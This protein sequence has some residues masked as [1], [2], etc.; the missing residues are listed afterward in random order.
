MLLSIKYTLPPGAFQNAKSASCKQHTTHRPVNKFK[1]PQNSSN[2]GVHKIHVVGIWDNGHWLGLTFCFQHG[3]SNSLLQLILHVLA[4]CEFQLRY[5]HLLFIFKT[6][7]NTLFF[8]KIHNTPCMF[9]ACILY[10]L[11]QQDLSPFYTGCRVLLFAKNN[12]INISK[13]NRFLL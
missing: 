13:S 1:S 7:M 3:F 6:C 10:F 11:F 12:P 9:K 4:G 8:H 2:I 5:S